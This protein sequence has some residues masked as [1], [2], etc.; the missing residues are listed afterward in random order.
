MKHTARQS[1]LTILLTLLEDPDRHYSNVC[2]KHFLQEKLIL[3]LLFSGNSLLL[4]S[5]WEKYSLPQQVENLL[6]PLLCAAVTK[7]LSIN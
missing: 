3:A 6:S 5:T 1:A 2:N 7:L 4:V